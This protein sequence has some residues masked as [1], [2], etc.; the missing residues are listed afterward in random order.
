[1]ERVSRDVSEIGEYVRHLVAAKIDGVRLAIRK[2]IIATALGLFGLL[3][4]AALLITSIVLLLTGLSGAFTDWFDSPLWVGDLLA[5]GLALALLG[6]A[7][8]VVHRRIAS[9]SRRKTIAKHEQRH[10]EQ[11]GRFGHDVRARAAARRASE[12]VGVPPA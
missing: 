5:G 3:A 12:R 7:I 4:A 10:A 11:R 1:L 2:A 8:F 9:A 6:V